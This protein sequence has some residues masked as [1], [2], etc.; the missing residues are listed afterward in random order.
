VLVPADYVY[1][2]SYV[3]PEA[4]WANTGYRFADA[5]S[6]CEAIGYGSDKSMHGSMGKCAICGASF[7]TGDIWTH[8]PT[9][10]MVHVGH[11]CADKVELA[12]NAG[13]RRALNR[14]LATIKVNRK[15]N[16]AKAADKAAVRAKFFAHWPALEAAIEIDHPLCRRLAAAIDARTVVT[17]EEIDAVLI[18]AHDA[19]TR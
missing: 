2:M 5:R 17:Q 14:A 3:I 11:E 12:M 1:V 9:G 10:D 15:K 6:A 7:R 18:L 8:V 13:E 4:N 16:K 19:T